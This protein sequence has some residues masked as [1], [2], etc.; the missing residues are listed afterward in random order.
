MV[1]IGMDNEIVAGAATGLGIWFADKVFGKA[2]EPLGQSLSA[3]LASRWKAISDRS[4]E[5]ASDNSLDPDTIS[6]GLLARMIMNASFSADT[7]QITEWWANLFVNASIREANQHAVFSDMMALLGP[8]EVG[9]LEEIISL[10]RLDATAIA[11]LSASA[12]ASSD[13]AFE[14][15][16]EEW[17]GFGHGPM[18]YDEAVQRM[19]NGPRNWAYRPTEWRLPPRDGSEE[20]RFAFGY[21]PWAQ[22]RVLE[23]A[24][25]QRTGILR[26]LSVTFSVWGGELWV[27]GLGLTTLGAN[28]YCACK[29]RSPS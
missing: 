8:A 18:A 24:I 5:I 4:G 23:L 21:D 7:P 13:T 6:P 2:V 28:F 12:I 20:S 26:P 10:C 29:G 9:C 14:H 15:A 16:V 1:E 17:I 25:L 11:D 19:L 22:E 27:R 3:F